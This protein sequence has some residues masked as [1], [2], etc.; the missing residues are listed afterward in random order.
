MNS[1]L[2]VDITYDVLVIGGGV[3]GCAVLWAL[4]HYDLRLALAEAASDV[5]QGIS[6]A[7]TAL[8]HTGF[9]APPGSLE[10]R[11]ITASHR[12]FAA[13]CADLGVDLRPCGA[14]MLA[15]DA[16]ELRQLDTYERR[17]TANG[18]AAVRLPGEA[19]RARWPYVNPAAL[20]GLHIPGEAAVDSFALTQANA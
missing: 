12:R 18:I 19:V 3:V 11:L 10:A 5:G 16:A 1:S 15:L 17:A 7:N 4:A 14:L 2:K 20:A 9:D 13:L 8:A 6:R